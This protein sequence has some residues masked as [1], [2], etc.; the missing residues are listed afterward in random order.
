MNVEFSQNATNNITDA[1]IQGT[2]MQSL[3]H[4]KLAPTYLKFG[5]SPLMLF[6]LFLGYIS[7]QVTEITDLKAILILKS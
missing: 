2:R 1:F 6:C 3:I 7:K 5:E 4:L